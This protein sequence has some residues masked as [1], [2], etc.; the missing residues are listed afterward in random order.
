VGAVVHYVSGYYD[1]PKCHPA[2]VTEVGQYVVVSTRTTV[3]KSFDRSEGRPIREIQTEQWW[4]S[5]GCALFVPT[6]ARTLVEG[7]K[8]AETDAAA[9]TWH[10]VHP[11][12]S[13]A[14]PR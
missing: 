5:D 1:D 9:G 12:Y 2:V 7:C 11:Q 8:H 10:H 13:E 4:Y 14:V 6:L 3:P